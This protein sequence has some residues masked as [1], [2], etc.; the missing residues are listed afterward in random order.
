[1]KKTFY[2][3][4]MLIGLTTFVGCN[5]MED[6][7][8]EIDAELDNKLAIADADYTLTEDDYEELGQ[9]FPNLLKN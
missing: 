3:L 5:P 7:H 9:N 2:Y 4:T 8:D 6:I 1:M